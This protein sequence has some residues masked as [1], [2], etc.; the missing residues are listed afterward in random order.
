MLQ[1]LIDILEDISRIVNFD[2]SSMRLGTGNVKI[3]I[4]K[5]IWISIPE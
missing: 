5:E 1:V 3:D 2:L 4:I